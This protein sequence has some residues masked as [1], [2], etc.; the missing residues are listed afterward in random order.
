MTSS[1]H[2]IFATISALILGAFAIS[3]L[4]PTYAG[5]TLPNY[6]SR[7]ASSA[8]TTVGPQ[9]DKT[10]FEARELCATRVVTTYAQPVS[11]SFFAS[12]TF[13]VSPT[14]GHL[15]GASTTVAY[16]AELYGCGQVVASAG[17]ST[18]ITVSEFA[19]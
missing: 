8:T 2:F 13:N 1:K 12:S 10:L 16:D 19:F 9:T 3:V 18:T 17:A 7:I 4:I 6:H 5:A 14:E 15:Q 11:I